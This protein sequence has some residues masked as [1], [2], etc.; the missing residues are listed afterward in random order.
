MLADS[1][2]Q[3]VHRRRDACTTLHRPHIAA[4]GI[5]AEGS[6]V[7]EGFVVRAGSSAVFAEVPS[8]HAYIRELRAALASNGV[9][10]RTP[11][12]YVFTQDYTFASPSTAAGVVQG[13]SANGR[14]DWKTKSGRTLKEMQEAESTIDPHPA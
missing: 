6:V 9:L 12:G 14:V 3:R 4:K 2:N 13:R 11:D 7:S 1:R 5:K 10:Q 8:C